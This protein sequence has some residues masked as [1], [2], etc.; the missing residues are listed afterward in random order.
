M[1]TPGAFGA[2]AAGTT[3]L[4]GFVLLCCYG[5]NLS[6]A[7]LPLPPW[8]AAAYLLI[9]GVLLGRAGRPKTSSP[10]AHVAS[11]LVVLIG[12]VSW[13]EHLTAFVTPFDKLLFP[14]SLW[15][16]ALHPGRPAP[17]SSFVFVLLGTSLILLPYLRAGSRC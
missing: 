5:L 1:T 14:G 11:G 3:A 7:W 4:I 13:V 6:Q 15:T 17:L 10:L 16:Q 9:G 8:S 12:A 2:A